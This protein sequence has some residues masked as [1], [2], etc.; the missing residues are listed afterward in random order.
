MES[1]FSM[2]SV[3]MSGQNLLVREGSVITGR[4]LVTY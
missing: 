1:N 3:S 2:L 4:R